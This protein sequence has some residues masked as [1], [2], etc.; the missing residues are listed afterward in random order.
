[1]KTTKTYAGLLY[2]QFLWNIMTKTKVYKTYTGLY[3]APTRHVFKMALLAVTW[4]PS[5]NLWYMKSQRSRQVYHTVSLRQTYYSSQQNCGFGL[6]V[7]PR[8]SRDL[9]TA[10]LYTWQHNYPR[11]KVK[12]LYL[13]NYKHGLQLHP[14][15]HI[16]LHSVFFRLS[17]TYFVRCAKCYNTQ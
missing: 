11:L 3:S 16:F 17:I 13:E 7:L 8:P 6:A 2:F 5:S 1:M 9:L 15:S 12:L 4:M 14:C 10:I